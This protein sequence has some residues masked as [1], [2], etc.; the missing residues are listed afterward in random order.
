MRIRNL[1]GADRLEPG[2]AADPCRSCGAKDGVLDVVTRVRMW[3]NRLEPDDFVTTPAIGYKC[4]GCGQDWTPFGLET[5]A[6]G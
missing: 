6:G 4:A 3:R 5:P 2:Y 1:Q